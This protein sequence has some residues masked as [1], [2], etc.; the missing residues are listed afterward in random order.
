[1]NGPPGIDM[2]QTFVVIFSFFLMAKDI[3]EISYC[4]LVF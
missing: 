4:L 1:M 2:L 3:W